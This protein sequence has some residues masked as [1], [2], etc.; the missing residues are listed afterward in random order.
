MYESIHVI[1]V[2]GIIG[3]S[4][5]V[6]YDLDQ[7]GRRVEIT[8][9]PF[10]PQAV[11]TDLNDLIEEGITRNKT[12]V[13]LDMGNIPWINAKGLGTLIM[14]SHKL[15]GRGGRLALARMDPEVAKMVASANSDGIF[16]VFDRV[17]GARDHLQALEKASTG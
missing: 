13:I 15:E 2:L 5:Y 9:Y 1:R 6:S 3:K 12:H 14:L 11:P 16:L 8:R 4:E 17:A 10:D 7:Q